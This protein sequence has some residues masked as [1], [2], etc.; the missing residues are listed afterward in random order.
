MGRKSDVGLAGLKARHRWGWSSGG[1][2]GDICFLA[3]PALGGAHDASSTPSSIF[4][5]LL[6][7]WAPPSRSHHVDAGDPPHPQ[8]LPW[9]T[10]SPQI[11]SQL[12]G[13]LGEGRRAQQLTAGLKQ[14]KIIFS[15]A[16]GQSLRS[17]CGQGWLPP[18]A[19][20]TALPTS[21]SF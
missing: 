12:A 18:K 17:G 2:R 21:S 6:P 10:L 5:A 8:L 13:L 16:G 1:S 9:I 20:G 3:L 15:Q 11:P 19:P 7:T 14:Q 4:S